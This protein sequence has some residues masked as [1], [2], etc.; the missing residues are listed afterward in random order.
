VNASLSAGELFASAMRIGRDHIS[1]AVN[2]LVLAYAGAALPLMLFFTVSGKSLGQSISAQDV[3]SEVVR[4]LAGSIG[5]V[6]SVPITTAVAAL[7][8]SREPARGGS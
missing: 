1:S 6:A 3:A 8:A 2:T 4:T 7:V 5:L